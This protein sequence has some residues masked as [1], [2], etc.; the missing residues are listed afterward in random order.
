M[1]RSPH[2]PLARQAERRLRAIEGVLDQP[3]LT[4]LAWIQRRRGP[5]R[6]RMAAFLRGVRIV[7]LLLKL[8]VLGG[9]LGD[10]VADMT[11]WMVATP[12]CTSPIV[13]VRVLVG[14]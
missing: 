12:D 5:R 6:G 13:T 1:P 11:E 14:L 2:T 4:L 7:A 8:T 9:L 3:L 10:H